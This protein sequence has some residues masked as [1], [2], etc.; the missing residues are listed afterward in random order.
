MISGRQSPAATRDGAEEEPVSGEG[1][2]SIWHV[3]PW[4]TCVSWH[5]STAEEM[6]MTE[7][8]E[9][10]EIVLDPESVLTE[11]EH[12]SDTTTGRARESEQRLQMLYR[13]SVAICQSTEFDEV[14]AQAVQALQQLLPLDRCFVAILDAKR[15]LKPR[16][17]VNIS[18]PEDSSAWPVSRTILKRVL[19]HERAI[20][21]HDAGA[22]DDYRQSRNVQ[23]YH[24]RS[25]MCVPLGDCE[26]CCGLI[27]VDNQ[28]EDVEG[29]QHDDLLLLTALSHYISLALRNAETISS[30]QAAWELSEERAA[31]LQK[32]LLDEYK[33]IARS[34]QMLKAFDIAKRVAPRDVPV[35]LMG[36]T[37]TG[38]DCFARLIHEERFADDGNRSNG[39]G[40][41]ARHPYVTLSVA[42]LSEN[43]VESELFGHEKGAFSG[44][45]TRRSGRIEQ[46][47]GGTLFLD[48]VGEIPLHLQ[49][50]LLRVIESHEFVRVGGNEKVRSGFR[51]VCATHQNLE[52]MVED[53][54]FRQDLY[55]R[56]MGVTI[57]LPPLRERI[58]DI[59]QL[60]AY[61]LS[62]LKS[63]RHFSKA[64]IRRLQSY[65]WPGNVRQLVH[66]V[67]TVDTLCTRDEIGP[68]DL[69]PP[70]SSAPSGEEPLSRG[71][72][73]LDEVVAEAEKQHILLALDQTDGN[74]G[75][76]AELLGVS[77]D[78]LW[79]RLRAYGL[80]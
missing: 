17:T 12:L 66:L 6:A 30:V 40:R 62:K 19:K 26:G 7:A 54:S 76:A 3:L 14:I 57:T 51:L 23:K 56:L 36:E 16:A 47:N 50:K 8:A 18:L 77:R 10:D 65:S 20:L 79:N 41:R 48:E 13:L 37:G 75:K 4:G 21:T 42:E 69:L 15:K 22:D 33:I 46:A 52:S 25:T 2:R 80:L 44:A 78:K 60:A 70:L 73:K 31:C 55:Y 67:E 27:Y 49:T 24:I 38:K 72:H 11:E 1:A 53:G 71:F 39:E 58:E 5:L 43:L 74:K 29:F 28:G 45:A 9:K 34:P 35:L 64:A 32:E 63:H 68:G 61:M 59:P